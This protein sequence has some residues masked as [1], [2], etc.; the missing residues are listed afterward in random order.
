MMGLP[1]RVLGPDDLLLSNVSFSRP[2]SN[3]RGNGANPE[4]HDS[5]ASG[6]SWACHFPFLTF[7]PNSSICLMQ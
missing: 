7:V 2:I 3:D 4:P 5:P 6:E 1:A